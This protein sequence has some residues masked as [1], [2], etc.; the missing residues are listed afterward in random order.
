MWKTRLAAILILVAGTALG[1]F[2]YSSE[3]ASE[4]KFPFRYGLDLSGGTRLVY[5]ADVSKVAASDVTTSM[6]SLRDVIERRVN[7]FGVAEPIVQVEK[8]SVLGGTGDDERL[9]VELPG[10]TDIDAAIAM[11]G[12]TP[13]LEFKLEK[14][15]T[16]AIIQ[17]KQDAQ[18]ALTSGGSVSLNALA[19]Q[20]PFAD[21]GLTGRF[22]QKASLEFDQ[23]TNEP[24]VSIIFNQ[25]G[26]DLFA[27][28]TRENVDKT[29]A[30]YLDGSPISTPV[31]RE[32]ITG[33]KAQIS[34]SMNAEEAKMLVGRL[35]SGALPIPISLASTEAV[36]PS[37]GMQA[38][39]AGVFAGLMGILVVMAFMVLWYRAPGVLASIA[40]LLYVAIMLAIFKFLP[41]TLT[42]AGI[43]GFILSVGMAVDA[44][45]LIFERMK[46]EL[47]K[48]HAGNKESIVE[49]SPAIKEGFH[50][51]WS[52]IRDGNISS[53]ITAV[54]LFWFGTSVV[55]GFALTFGLG[56]LV[57]MLSAITIS[58]TFLV[59]VAPR[60][61]KG[62]SRFLFNSGFSR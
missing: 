11:I 25:E 52:S 42:A 20:D 18:K 45:I 14:S 3:I 56:V 26:S 27:K 19:F 32:E 4:S 31:I 24:I 21:T 58:R 53:M 5:N 28:I 38:R 13:L 40:L 9:I 60:R 51:A 30:I 59:A 7:L 1:Y 46:E 50:R 61:H 43:A 35:N 55:Q 15:D 17:A 48:A 33:G 29:L 8:G 37:L 2:V 6:N 22:L 16:Q 44:N 54:I 10:V 41:V 49:L 62:I 23:T 12:Q 39:D 57:S 34:G 47:K 36:G